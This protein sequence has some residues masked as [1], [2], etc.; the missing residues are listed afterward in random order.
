MVW[1]AA[2][3]AKKRSADQP[4]GASF[5]HHAQNLFNCP[6]LGKDARLALVV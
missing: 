4:L 3:F 5:D 1:I 2:Q 6:G